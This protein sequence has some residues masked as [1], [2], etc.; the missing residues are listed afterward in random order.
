M[1]Q[2]ENDKKIS[3]CHG[4]ISCDEI[5]VTK[6]RWVY[7]LLDALHVKNTITIILSL[8]VIALIGAILTKLDLLHVYTLAL[9][10]ALSN[11]MHSY[12]LENIRKVPY[13]ETLE[14][15]H[16]MMFTFITMFAINLLVEIGK[17]IINNVT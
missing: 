14:N 13:Y 2:N 8:L 4:E 1:A 11:A 5:H 9:G 7:V 16:V 15:E 12:M 10:H 6:S 3:K 17:R